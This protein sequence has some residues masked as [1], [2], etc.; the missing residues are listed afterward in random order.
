MPKF[1]TAEA[2]LDSIRMVLIEPDTALDEIA[3][4]VYHTWRIVGSFGVRVWMTMPFEEDYKTPAYKKTP[5]P[6]LAILLPEVVEGI[7]SPLPIHSPFSESFAS[8]L[9][10]DISVGELDGLQMVRF[11]LELPG[12]ANVSVLMERAPWVSRGKMP[13]TLSVR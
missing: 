6:H 9:V 4:A 3:E 12:T 8:R 11:D 1:E 13:V 2:T 10:T 7:Q 5:P